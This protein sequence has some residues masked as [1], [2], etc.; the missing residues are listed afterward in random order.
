[1]PLS[2]HLPQIDD[3]RFDDL[4][5]E[6]RTRIAR[7]APE[8][9]PGEAAWTDVN[10]NDPGITFAQVFAWQ[11]EML[12]Y[13]MNKVPL[14]NYIKFLQMVGI[15]LRPAEPA[16]AEVAFPLLPTYGERL[17][18]IPLRTQLSAQSG[19]GG[20]PLLFETVAPL[21]A[22]RARLDAVLA[23]DGI[24]YTELTPANDAGAPGFLPFGPE[25]RAGAELA[26][27]FS[28]PDPLPPVALDLAITA[29]AAAREALACGP[30]HLAR[31]APATI[32]WEYWDGAA[33][34]RLKVLKDET[35]AF[36][37][38][39]HVLLQ[40]PAAGIA[41]KTALGLPDERCW[42]RARLADSQY[43][44][45]PE[46]LAIRTNTVAA[47]QAES[48]HDEV[49]GGSDGSRSQR[50][51]LASTP[52]LAGSLALEIQQGEEGYEAW[53]EVPDFFGSGPADRHYALNR[54]T[55]EIVT[56]DGVNGAIPVAYLH[57]AGANVVARAYRVG[58]GARGNVPAGA[59]RTLTAA[60]DGVDANGVRNLAAATGGRDEES[61][62]AALRRAPRALRSSGRAVTAE[63]FEHF[64]RQA[65]DVA[66]AKALPLFHPRFPGSPVPGVVSV[67]VVPDADTAATPAPQPSDGTLRA[68]CACL[69]ARRLLAT[70]L[71]VLRPDYQLVEVRAEL[72]AADGA[73]LALLGEAVEAAL[74]SFFDPLRGG[75][76]GQGWPFGGTIYYSRVYH[77]VFEVAGV[78]RIGR[79]AVVLEGEERP[80]CSDIPIAVNGLLY[81]RGHEVAVHYNEDTPP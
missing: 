9:R 49:L 25:A 10:D 12:L 77:R 70:E 79:L 26:L 4:L 46:L 38:S 32:A 57:N 39:G 20:K 16:L 6:I 11:A 2:D 68:V 36:T 41:G 55:G 17:R 52:V 34:R 51:R 19:D 75:E 24:S 44:R 13:R 18:A 33:W 35:R 65:G 47:E 60:L 53:H 64:A 56:G 30:A 5:A 43:E 45:R 54:S 29:R 78:E 48:L 71:F 69:D 50:F 62:E 8:W 72:V 21:T 59:I 7:Y 81:S 27:G 66:R 23:G 76:D 67:I 74:T 42:I 61:L 63:D 1:M 22:L 37:R 80:Q 31:Y 40:L 3:R 14:L 73:D 58:G 28:D 15:E